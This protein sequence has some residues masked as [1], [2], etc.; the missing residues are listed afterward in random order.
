MRTKFRIVRL[1]LELHLQ[2]PPRS[3]KD[4]ITDAVVRVPNAPEQITASDIAGWTSLEAIAESFV[5]RGL[6]ARPGLSDGNRLVL[7]L[8]DDEFI[9][10]VKADSGES[11]TD[12]KPKDV[13]RRHTNL[14]ATN[15]FEEFTFLTRVRTF[16]QK[17]GQIKHQKLTFTKSQFTSDSGA[18]N[19]ILQKFNQIEYGSSAAIYGDLYDTQQIVKE[20]YEDFED[21]RTDLVQEVSGIPDD[22]GDAK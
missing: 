21:L 17:H 7:Q 3:T 16:G 12:F 6:R 5:K 19:T 22:R 20:F 14:V 2:N 8:A 4:F 11:A 1:K 15:D 13:D 18:K 10:L 9:E